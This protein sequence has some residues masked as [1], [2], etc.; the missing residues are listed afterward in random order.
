MAKER[1]V[2]IFVGL[3]V[4]L[5]AVVIFMI[6]ENRQ[7]F[8]D[9]V[10]FET[11]FLDVSGLKPGA[12]VRMGGV[13]NGTVSKVGHSK[14]ANDPKI[15]VGFDVVK[16]EA[17][18]VR[19]DSV[20]RIVM[21]GLLGD[22]MIELSPGVG[23]PVPPKGMVKS[24]DPLDFGKYVSKFESIANRTEKTVENL[25]IA[26]RNLGDPKVTDDVKQTIAN[27]R[28]ITDGV[29][30]NK[31]G[32][33]HKFLYDPETAKKLDHLVTNVDTLSAQLAVA[34][35]D[36]SEV[37]DRVKTGPG[38]AHSVLYD[39]KLAADLSGTTSEVRQSLEAVR[40]QNGLM[41]GVIYG[42]EHSQ[43][44][45]ANL[46]GTLGDVRQ[47]VAHVRAGK[48][49]LG[50]FL[51]D[52]SIYEDVKQLVGNVDRNQV[53]RALVRYSIKEDETKGEGPK[54]VKTPDVG[55]K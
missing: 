27:V 25:E 10:T 7:V 13:D 41:H 26:S 30:N 14:E 9:K 16:G 37:T 50:G 3:G 47:I 32:A 20:A 46:A 1:N 19:D 29:A 39:E 55:Q 54:H 6:G 33:A 12:P 15:Q 43:S 52:P 31:D 18:R 4:L 48:G 36:L 40:T 51:M 28:S 42:D 21:K 5:S 17:S 49:S 22:K 38:L 24:E 11:E 23:G 34:S 35:R 8:S 2:G 44:A 45:M 53:L